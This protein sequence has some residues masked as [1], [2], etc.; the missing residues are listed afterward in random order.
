[1][2][3]RRI[4]LFTNRSLF[5]TSL[6]F[7]IQDCN[8]CPIGVLM[9][10]IF[11]FYLLVSIS[12]NLLVFEAVKTLKCALY[13]TTSLTYH[14]ILKKAMV[15]SKFV[16]FSSVGQMKPSKAQK[17]SLAALAR[18][19]LEYSSGTELDSVITKYKFKGAAQRMNLNLSPYTGV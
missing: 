15:H 17:S 5:T 9:P 4:I 6:R 3:R 1:M 18:N 14:D 2:T 13:I 8:S 7:K 12:S 16:N 11:R 19:D 10:E